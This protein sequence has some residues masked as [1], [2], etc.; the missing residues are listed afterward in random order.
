MK[1]AISVVVF[2]LIAGAMYLIDAS[3]KNTPVMNTVETIR[4]LTA[5]AMPMT[6]SSSVFTEGGS[7]PSRYTCDADNTNPPLSWSGAPEA[8]KSFALIMD[9]PDIPDSVKQARG[10]DVFDHWVVYNIPADTNAI[11]E[12]TKPAGQEGLNGAGDTQYRG[13]CPPDKEHRYFFYLFALDT[14]LDFD[15]AP[16]K[17]QLLDAMKGHVVGQAQLMGLYNR[18]QK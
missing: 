2:A 14:V 10:I 13:P 8:T 11:A 9:D 18:Q 15:S 3:Y 16:T 17:A 1:Y 4:N 7:I 5:H 6:L 12:A